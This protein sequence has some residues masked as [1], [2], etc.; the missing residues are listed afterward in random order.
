MKPQD[1]VFLAIFVLVLFSRNPKISAILGLACLILSIPLFA[2]WVF[3]TAERLVWYA[4]LF[5]L[6]S[7]MLNLTRLNGT[8]RTTS[9]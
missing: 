5:F 4:F 1:L 9:K 7:G 6:L 8:K 3:F 2:L